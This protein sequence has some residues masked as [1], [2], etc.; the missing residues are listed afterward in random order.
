MA[1]IPKQA[2][3]F[4]LALKN[5]WSLNINI[6]ADHIFSKIKEPDFILSFPLFNNPLFAIRTRQLA[7][8][9]RLGFYHLSS[10]FHPQSRLPLSKKELKSSLKEAD[11]SLSPTR[12]N[13][14]S[15]LLVKYIKL[16]PDRVLTSSP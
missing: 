12:L 3:H 4:R 10:L 13:A 14:L 2:T 8:W 7:L 11:R 1:C 16:I 9:T 5:F 15:S 6:D